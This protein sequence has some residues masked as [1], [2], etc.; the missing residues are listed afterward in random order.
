M[1]SLLPYQRTAL[2]Q[3]SSGIAKGHLSLIATGRSTGKSMMA[4]S[5]ILIQWRDIYLSVENTSKRKFPV[6]AGRSKPWD[7]PYGQGDPAAARETKVDLDSFPKDRTVYLKPA[8]L[9]DDFVSVEETIFPWLK[10]NNIRLQGHYQTCKNG[11]VMVDTFF[12][13]RK[14]DAMFFKLVWG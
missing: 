1:T 13:K 3:Y 14:K 2:A 8:N 6:N 12:F 11:Q 7:S 10:E 9:R 4:A 5:S